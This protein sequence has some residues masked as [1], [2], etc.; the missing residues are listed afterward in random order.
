MKL[1]C[2][3]LELCQNGDAVFV[4]IKLGTNSIVYEVIFE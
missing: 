4:Y 1:K 2:F 3:G